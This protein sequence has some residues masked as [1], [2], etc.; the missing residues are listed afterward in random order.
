MSKAIL[1]FDNIRLKKRAFH[2]SKY[3]ININEKDN[4]KILILDKASYGKKGFKYF[5]GC[6][7]DDDEIKP[8]CIALPK[9]NIK[10]ICFDG[11]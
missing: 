7:D 10:K 8:L 3:P 6:K 4:K 1:N 11:N 9:I 5:T 2:N